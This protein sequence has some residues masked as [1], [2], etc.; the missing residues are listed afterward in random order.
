MSCVRRRTLRP[1]R[2]IMYRSVMP[3]SLPLN[4]SRRPSGD[5]LG[6]SA[7]S[8]GRWSKVRTMFCDLTS[9]MYRTSLPSFCAVKAS[10]RPSG[11]KALCE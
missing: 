2:S 5:Q 8:T 4:T 6:L 11:E 3:P 7:C 9:T 1:S 10:V